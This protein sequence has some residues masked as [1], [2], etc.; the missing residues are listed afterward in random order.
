MIKKIKRILMMFGKIFFAAYV[1]AVIVWAG[2]YEIKY[3]APKAEKVSIAGDFNGWNPDEFPMEKIDGGYFSKT[4]EL[5]PG[6]HEYKVIID[7]EW[8]D[9]ANLKYDTASRR[10][11]ITS[12]FAWSPKIFWSGKFLVNVSSSGAES[13]HSLQGKITLNNNVSGMFII[14]SSGRDGRL[15]SNAEKLS[16]VYR[17]GLFDL[18]SFYN[19]RVFQSPDPMRLLQRRSIPLRQQEIVFCDETNPAED[20]GLGAQGILMGFGGEGKAS[21]NLLI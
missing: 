4:L 20:F 18:N 5:E 10:T 16:I 12:N 7:G 9:G 19:L 13:C 2:E 11:I 15:N 21:A 3:Y 8:L 6:V 14:N 17:A 1:S